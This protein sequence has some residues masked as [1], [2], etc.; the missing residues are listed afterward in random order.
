MS[1]QQISCYA[2]FQTIVVNDKYQSKQATTCTNCRVIYHTTCWN[3]AN[4]CLNCKQTQ[5]QLVQISTQLPAQLTP[6]RAPVFMKP[7]RII[8]TFGK[9]NIP[10]SSEQDEKS[11]ILL[12]HPRVIEL[13]S[14]VN[15]NSQIVTISGVAALFTVI[16]SLCLVCFIC[17]VI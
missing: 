5:T 6:N 2:C 7:T 13:T 12:K 4:K 10:I 11:S 9:F 1:N 3:Q 17:A 16:G 8:Y 15:N 14:F